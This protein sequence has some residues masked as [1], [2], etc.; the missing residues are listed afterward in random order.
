MSL[1][2][3]LGCGLGALFTV[4]SPCTVALF[5]TPP[6][7]R[8]AI[9]HVPNSRMA[10][11]PK[12][13]RIFPRC[14]LHFADRAFWPPRSAA[15]IMAHV[16]FVGSKSVFRLPV[17]PAYVQVDVHTRTV[18]KLNRRTGA[19]FFYSDAERVTWFIAT[20]ARYE[21]DDLESCCRLIPMV[22]MP[23]DLLDVELNSTAQVEWRV[24]FLHAPRRSVRNCIV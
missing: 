24:L 16:R 20:S 12:L 11:K 18:G 8:P 21:H 7:E 3:G 19:S 2:L 22:G 17:C 15:E 1:F 13:S 14:A 23:P 9:P 6:P 5:A 10:S 4:T